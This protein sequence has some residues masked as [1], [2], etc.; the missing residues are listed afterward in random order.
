MSVAGKGGGDGKAHLRWIALRLFC[1][2]WNTKSKGPERIYLSGPL[3]LSAYNL[4]NR[5]GFLAS[6]CGCDLE[7]LYPRL[8]EFS[9]RFATFY[10][11]DQC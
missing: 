7:R 11:A 5:G 9:A 8:H 6:L 2:N 4:V 1:L 3:L 10:M